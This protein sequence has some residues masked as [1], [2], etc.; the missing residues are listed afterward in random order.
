MTAA[1]ALMLAAALPAYAQSSSSSSSS[2]PGSSSSTPSTSASTSSTSTPH[3]V[4]TQ[5]QPGQIRATQMDGATVYDAQNQ[6]VGDIKDIILDRDGKVAAVVIDVGAFLGIGGKNVAVSMND[7]KITQDDSNKPRFTV[8]MTKDQLKSAQAYDLN[9]PSR[10]SS[11][12]S[13]TA[14][15]RSSNTSPTTP[16][17]Q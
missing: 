12:G 3:V 13:T 11:S 10:N 6:K 2:T 7:L 5:L 16:P 9:G 1:L 8:N 4:A 15:A 17:K 14:P